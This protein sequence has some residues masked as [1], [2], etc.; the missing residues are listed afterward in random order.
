MGV[1]KT[2]NQSQ[3]QFQTPVADEDDWHNVTDAKKRKKIQDRLAQRARRQRLKEAAAQ[4]KATRPQQTDSASD[5]SGPSRCVQGEPSQ[6]VAD[7]DQLSFSTVSLVSFPTAAALPC[8]SGDDSSS[9]S[10]QSEA[11]RCIVIGSQEQSQKPDNPS[12]TISIP[13][14]LTPL[15]AWFI[16]T[17]CLQLPPCQGMQ[18]TSQPCDPSVPEAL[19]PTP[20]QLMVPHSIG[21]DGFPFPHFRDNYILMCGLLFSEAE[22]M[23]DLHLS[24][25]FSI[26]PGGL[27]WDPR[28]WR[29][30]R[31]FAEKY[32]PIFGSM[33]EVDMIMA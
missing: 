28:S 1:L 31:Q 18:R 5:V 17:Q 15:A 20:T 10:T 33:L 25:S 11:S 21:I 12:L 23:H 32:A 3:S 6:S 27:P 2:R 9:S 22:F 14:L 13:H 24:S 30:H 7:E 26:V 19:H 8:S 29:V 16:N 4:A